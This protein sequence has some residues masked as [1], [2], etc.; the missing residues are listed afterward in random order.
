MVAATAV[1]RISIFATVF[2]G[3]V[4]AI[5]LQSLLGQGGLQF[6]IG[7]A[8][9]YIAYFAYKA[10]TLDEPRIIGAMA[11]LTNK[12]VVLLGSRKKGVVAEYP[13]GEIESLEMTRKGNILV[14]GKLAITPPD[15]ERLTFLTTN[16]HLARDFVVQF[17]EMRRRGFR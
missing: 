1:M 17:E 6:G 3:I 10:V 14:M 9:G 8:L 11:A 2:S 12:R 5:V 4:G 13:V 16:R 7:L 15:E